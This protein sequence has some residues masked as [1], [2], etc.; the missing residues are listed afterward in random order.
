MKNKIIIAVLLLLLL[1]PLKSKSQLNEIQFEYPTSV[2]FKSKEL[3][4]YELIKLSERKLIFYPF[5]ELL[6]VEEKAILLQSEIEFYQNREQF[7]L[8]ILNKYVSDNPKS[9]YIPFFY[10][11]I[12]QYNFEM[13]Q[14]DEAGKYFE[15]A[16]EVAQYEFKRRNDTA[17]KE[18]SARSLFW[19]GISRLLAGKIDLARESLELCFR[20]FQ[21][22]K[23]ADEALFYLGLIAQIKGEEETAI[24]YFKTLQKI[25]PR[26]NLIVAS[27][28]HEA[29]NYI[30]LKQDVQALV[31]LD[32]AE[33]VLARIRS[34]DSVGLIYE[35]QRNIDDVEERIFFLRAEALKI[36]RRYDEAIA[37]YSKFIETYPKSNYRYDAQL[38]IGIS[39][40]EKGDILKSIEI[41]DRLINE[42]Q[43]ENQSQ[44]QL[45]ELYRAVA[46]RMLG[47]L[48]ESQTQLS[49]L[50][51]KSNYPYQSIGL[52]ELGLIYYEKKEFERANKTLERALR[53]S[54]DNLLSA[55]I[56]LMLGATYLE[57]KQWEKAIQAYKNSEELAKRATLVQLPNKDLLIVEARLK[58]AIAQ[59][60]SNKIGEAIQN[61]LFVIGNFPNESRTEEALFWLAEAYY[62]SD[63]LRNA[64]D[65]YESLLSKYSDTKFREDALY[66]L[67]W[68]YFRLKNFKKSSEVFAQLLREFPTTK[69]GMEVWLR[70]G[71]G[72][73]VL[74]DFRNAITSYR[75]VI[76]IAPKSEE[77][78]Y[79]NYQICH[80]LYKLGSLNDAYNE[81]LEFIKRYP[82]SQ[83]ASNAL[84]LNGWIRFQQKN[85]PEAINSFNFLID[86]YPNSL[87]VPRAKYAIADALYNM[88]NF[89]EAAQ[90]YKEIIDNYPTS[91]LIADALRSLQYCYIAMGRDQEAMQIA[92][93]YISKNPES[94]F[95]ADFTLKKGEMF[96]T[97]KNF[98]NAIAEYQNFIQKFPENERKPEA[99]YWMGKSY[100]NLGDNEN[101]ISI[102]KEIEKKYSESEYAP[103]SLLELGMI[104]KSIANIQMAD[105]CFT[106]VQEKY[107]ENPAS[108]QAGFE[109][110]NI[111]FTLG[112]T[113]TAIAIW[114]KIAKKFE[115]TEFGDQSLYK[116]AMY[117]RFSGKFDDAIKEFSKIVNSSTDPNLS[118]EAQYRIGEIYYRRGD[119]Q[120]AIEEFSKVRERYPNV[121][122]W[123]T[124]SLLN[125]G[126]CYEKIGDT[127]AAI[128]SYRAIVA[129]RETDDYTKTAKRRLQ[130][131]E[132][133]IK[134]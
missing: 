82:N 3:F 2:Y 83:Y 10:E 28:V 38:G 24:T 118:A 100:Q 11:K 102:F 58:Q 107:P 46:N 113:T 61:L 110:A 64:I 53:E 9:I 116:I 66:G 48:T 31:A 12:A 115:G 55:K 92:E 75:K 126:D 27:K 125:L 43:D 130:L 71:D 105:S 128:I 6:P 133:K 84:F 65:K 40:L 14:Y 42:I 109:Q 114:E 78:Q 52:L 5:K 86:A 99:L 91:P 19:L 81:V 96:Y 79:A 120:K 51:A 87:L 106:K 16:N 77:A 60:K 74:K 119:F 101:A 94:P 89:E 104:Y 59:I 13:K 127:E 34:R 129:A 26:S 33:T 122:D 97:G 35:P 39:L 90:K 123:Y 41:F 54:A 17:Y 69:Y 45:A 49:E 7:A 15:K 37:N 108:A 103:Q 131:L 8:D 121:E 124:L 72:Y 68:S 47:R 29:S 98:K 25:Y 88:N 20:N 32:F 67:G 18:L 56:Y 30:A 70:Q 62:R 132:Q 73:F 22:S 85:Y 44:R 117:Y 21:D 80:S 50:V 57:L 93:D 23:S 111:K 1:I 112:D 4:D 134:N 63:M 95:A 36:S 76:E